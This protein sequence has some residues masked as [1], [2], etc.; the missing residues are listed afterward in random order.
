MTLMQLTTVGKSEN[1]GPFSIIVLQR[2]FDPTISA[3]STATLNS[4]L[5]SHNNTNLACTAEGAVN[6]NADA[7]ILISGNHFHK[8]FSFQ[9]YSS[10][11]RC[12][13]QTN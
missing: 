10:F 2:T 4:A 11:I 1:F 8:T 6:A 9:L 3:V 12:N 7:T 13:F 5:L